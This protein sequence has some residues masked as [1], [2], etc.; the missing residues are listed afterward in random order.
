MLIGSELRLSAN[1]KA[2]W[3]ETVAA[4]K[5]EGKLALHM[6]PTVNAEKVIYACQE[7]YPEIKVTTGIAKD[8]SFC[9]TPH[10]RK[11]GQEVPHLNGD[12]ARKALNILGCL[13]RRGQ[14]KGR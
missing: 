13:S 6:V 14:I 11:A 12:A 10:D 2:E 3:E 4:A 7:K 1:W 9:R 8:R 5:K